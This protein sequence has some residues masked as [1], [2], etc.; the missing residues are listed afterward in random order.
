MPRPMRD[1]ARIQAILDAL[2]EVWREQPDLRLTQLLTAA[3]GQRRNMGPNPLFY[4]E[5]DETLEALRS[6]RGAK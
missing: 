2:G 6:Y 3:I 5:D 1:P 4:V